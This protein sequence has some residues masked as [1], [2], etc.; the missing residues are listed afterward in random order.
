MPRIINSLLEGTAGDGKESNACG[1]TDSK[2]VNE[3]KSGVLPTVEKT[4]A[5]KPWT[6]TICRNSLTPG[7]SNTVVDLENIPPSDNDVVV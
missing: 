4:N 7:K 5:E 6:A 2:E 1:Q 3:V